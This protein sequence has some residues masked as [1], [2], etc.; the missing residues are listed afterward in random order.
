MLGLLL[1]DELERVP[2][3]ELVDDRWPLKLQHPQR[4]R[5]PL[6]RSGRAA[7]AVAHL[8]HRTARTPQRPGDL[9]KPAAFS[10]P[11]SNLLVP[12]H[13][14]AARAHTTIP[15]LLGHQRSGV[16]RRYGAIPDKRLFLLRYRH[17]RVPPPAPPRGA[18]KRGPRRWSPTEEIGWSRTQEIRWSSTQ[19]IAWV[20]T[21]EIVQPDMAGVRGRP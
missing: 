10:Q 8:P 6:G 18:S 4:I 15:S 7:K 3:H 11:S 19:E 1:P 14:H 20:R 16:G 17:W 9:A 12:P 13:R 21:Q 5:L 2:Q